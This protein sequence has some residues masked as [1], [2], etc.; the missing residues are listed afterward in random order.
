MPN[1]ITLDRTV[2]LMELTRTQR[3]EH[4]GVTARQPTPFVCICYMPV[5]QGRHSLL[6]VKPP[7]VRLGR[8]LGRC[9]PDPFKEDLRIQAQTLSSM[10]H[11]IILCT[12][13]D[14]SIAFSY[15]S[16]QFVFTA[17]QTLT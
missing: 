14:H 9:H 4:L 13:H 12:D 6:N 1:T 2:S 11:L 3:K 10:T 8:S 15:R 17:D 7:H 16:R 5:S